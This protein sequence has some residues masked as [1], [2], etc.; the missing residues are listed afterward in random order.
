MPVRRLSSSPRHS[1]SGLPGAP[2]GRWLILIPALWLVGA[3]LEI[4]FF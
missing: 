4:W 2:S 3:G 1:S